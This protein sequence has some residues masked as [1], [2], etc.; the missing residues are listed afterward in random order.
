[1]VGRD[2]EDAARVKA[3]EKKLLENPEISALIDDLVVSTDD[4]NDL[5]R[6]L[7][8]ASITRGLQAEMDAHLGYKSGDRQGRLESGST[9]ARNGSYAKTVQSNYGPLQIDVPR[10]REGTFVPRMVPKGSRRLTDVDD[11]IIS[12][13]AGGMTVRDI[14]HHLVSTMRIDISPDTI[15]TITDSV[16]E[17]MAEWQNRQLEDFYPVIFLD[18]IRIKVRESSRVVNKSAYLAI[19]ISMEGVKSILGIWV[20]KEEGSSFWARVCAEMANRGVRDVFI[21]CCDGLKGLPDAIEATWPNSLVQTC[22]VHLIR[23][24][25]RWVSYK[26]RKAVAGALRRIYTA[27]SEEEAWQALQDFAGSKLGKQYPQSAQV[28][29]DAWDRFIP[30]LQFPPAARKV[31]Y[32]TNSIESMNSELRKATRN[33]IQFTNDVAAV[34]A[35]WL[36][37]GH[38]EDRRARKRE[39]QA[40]KLGKGK[41]RGT[42]GYIEGARASGWGQAINQMM[43]AYPERFEKYQ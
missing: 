35:L 17:E 24:S 2:V 21:V 28:W 29:I 39:K 30:F 40:A 15:S 42:T 38:I 14:Q 6:S 34:K 22:V 3:L 7:I 19:G 1:M 27:A 10:D 20:A 13:Y 26:D 36:M 18:A 25:N 12:L 23:A 8:Q 31:I 43:V 41:P 5:V 16:L 11:L 37:I 9:N 32:T 4:A 33:R